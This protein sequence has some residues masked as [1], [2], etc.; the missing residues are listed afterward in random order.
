MNKLTFRDIKKTDYKDAN[1]VFTGIPFDDNA[2]LGKGASHA[3]AFLRALSENIPGVTRAAKLLDKVSLFDNGDIVRK[4]KESIPSYFNRVEKAVSP[5]FAPG[6]LNVFIGGDHSVNIPL[7]K[8][9]LSF[10]DLHHKTPVLIHIDA[11]PDMMDDYLDNRLSHATP[12]RRALDHGLKQENL[13]FIGLRGFERE[14]V[15]YFNENPA[16]TVYLAG[17]VRRL[18]TSPIIESVTKRFQSDEYAIYVSYDIDANDPA[19]APGTGTPE[20]F[21]LKSLDTLRLTSAFVA[22][23]NTYAI[24]FVEISPPLDVND[25]TSWLALKTL[26]ELFYIQGEKR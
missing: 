9:F 25:M 8:A 21:G 15:V 3:P 20:A 17:D 23:K 7:F 18:G 16:I 22:L 4:E 2:S 14:E 26:Y 12:A 5:L 1:I 11:H 19:Y 24:D 10:C 13:V 6:K